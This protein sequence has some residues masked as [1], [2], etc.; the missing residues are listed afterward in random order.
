VIYHPTLYSSID[1]ALTHLAGLVAGE[2]F[3]RIKYIIEPSL[4]NSATSPSMQDKAYRINAFTPI[5]D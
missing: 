5:P 2:V 1:R 3:S 4:Q